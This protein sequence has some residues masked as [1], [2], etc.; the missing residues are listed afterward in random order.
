MIVTTEVEPSTNRR[1]STSLLIGVALWLTSLLLHQSL[2]FWA[3][4]QGQDY[5]MQLPWLAE[6]FWAVPIWLIPLAGILVCFIGNATE[7]CM[8]ERLSPL[9]FQHSSPSPLSVSV[10]MTLT[11]LGKGLLTKPA[12][13]RYRIAAPS[14]F[15]TL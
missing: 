13:L 10:D 6:Q 15:E 4:T 12:T 2:L 1:Y 5:G 3:V 9:V 14:I 8:R 11:K 7:R